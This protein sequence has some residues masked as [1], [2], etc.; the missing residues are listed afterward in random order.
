MT[1][2]TLTRRRLLPGIVAAPLLAAATSNAYASKK[3]ARI[4]GPMPEGFRSGPLDLAKPL[5]NLIALL[6][7]QADLAGKPFQG[8]VRNPQ[9][10]PLSACQPIICRMSGNSS[11]SFI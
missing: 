6:K 5:D 3:R 11:N 1:R 4:T 10:F 9:N 7:L 8:V 2:P